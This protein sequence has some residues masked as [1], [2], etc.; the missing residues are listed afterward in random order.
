MNL[1]IRVFFYSYFKRL[2]GISFKQHQSRML[3]FFKF[4]LIFK[5]FRTFLYMPDVFVLFNPDQMIAPM[6]E[7]LNYKIPV[8]G[9]L[10]TNSTDFGLTY[11]IYS[12]D[13]SIL[14]IMFYVKLFLKI[15]KLGKYYKLVD[16]SK[17]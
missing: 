2:D 3:K 16:G 9:L 11:P 6:S 14:L 8:I 1:L 4:I 13:D 15:I 5:Y 17:I 12:N 10:D 7:V